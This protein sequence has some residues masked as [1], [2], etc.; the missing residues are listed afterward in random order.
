M[1]IWVVAVGACTYVPESENSTAHLAPMGAKGQIY[2]LAFNVNAPGCIDVVFFG[3]DRLP[4][5]SSFA[6]S[7]FSRTGI[8]HFPLALWRIMDRTCFGRPGF[9]ISTMLRSDFA[10]RNSKQVFKIGYLIMQ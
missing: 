4:L 7:W 8:D 3:H 6:H 10:T 9:S 5:K 1:A 2:P